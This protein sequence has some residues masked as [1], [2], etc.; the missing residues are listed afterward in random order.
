MLAGLA[1]RTWTRRIGVD[2]KTLEDKLTALGYG[3]FVPVVFVASGM[4]L[5]MAAILR[6]PLLTVNFVSLLLARRRLLSRSC[7]PTACRAAKSWRRP[8]IADPAFAARAYQVRWRR[9]APSRASSLFLHASA[10][11]H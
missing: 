8:A 1:F 9:S 11:R 3:L 5:D 10:T 7:T 6:D 4:T 2:V